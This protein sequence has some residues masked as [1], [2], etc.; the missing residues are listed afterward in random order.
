MKSN[1]SN[2]DHKKF[3][4]NEKSKKILRIQKT[5]ILLFINYILYRNSMSKL[6]FIGGN[7][8]CNIDK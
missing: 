8:S 1:Y 7:I 2:N 3:V 4:I 5:G 6:L